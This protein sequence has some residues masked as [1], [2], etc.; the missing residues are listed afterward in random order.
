VRSALIGIHLKNR[1][2]GLKITGLVSSSVAG[3]LIWTRPDELIRVIEESSQPD[4][5]VMT[6]SCGWCFDLCELV[7]VPAAAAGCE[8]SPAACGSPFD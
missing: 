2:I 6:R 1:L 8:A 4:P 7:H 3:R 5:K